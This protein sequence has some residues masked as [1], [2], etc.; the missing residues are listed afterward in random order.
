MPDVDNTLYAL[1]RG[2]PDTRTDEELEEVVDQYRKGGKLTRDRVRET[3]AINALLFKDLE[4][5]L[6]KEWGDKY[7]P[8]FIKFSMQDNYPNLGK[9]NASLHD[10][11][12]GA[13]NRLA[14]Y[15]DLYWPDQSTVSLSMPESE[16]GTSHAGVVEYANPTEARVG[17]AYAN[18][19]I[20][21]ELAHTRQMTSE[22]RAVSHPSEIVGDNVLQRLYRTSPEYTKATEVA[23]TIR[24][25]GE[26]ILP[27]N[28]FDGDK[29]FVA[30]L[31]GHEGALPANSKLSDSALLGFIM[32][33]PALKQ[34][35]MNA[36]NRW[37]ENTSKPQKAKQVG[38]ELINNI[39]NIL[40]LAIRDAFL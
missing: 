14:K 5:R 17:D 39:R 35:Y 10:S 18:Q 31:A 28:M 20:P 7:H 30:T 23:K 16:R 19:T 36:T 4:G 26:E 2:L 24:D 34:W 15:P 6:K 25:K 12:S 1:L 13:S 38:D 40:P 8:N 32:K 22:D 9:L 21:H 33:D 3:P 37:D 11:E 27:R 29:E